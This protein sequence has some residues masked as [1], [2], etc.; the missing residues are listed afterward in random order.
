MSASF[1]SYGEMNRAW[2]AEEVNGFTRILGNQ[3]R[4]WYAVNGME[5]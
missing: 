5:D 2:S 4:I 1:A 3:Q